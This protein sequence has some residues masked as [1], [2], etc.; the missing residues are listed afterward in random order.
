VGAETPGDQA[1][2]KVIAA[3]DTVADI[4][5]DRFATVKIRGVLRAH[6]RA[7]GHDYAREC[8]CGSV[9]QVVGDRRHADPFGSFA[10]DRKP[11]CMRMKRRIA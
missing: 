10:H 5:V 6:R 3:A 1:G 2:V 8:E 4:E 11:S 9:D 7:G